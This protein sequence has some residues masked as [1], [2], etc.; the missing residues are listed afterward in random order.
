LGKFPRLVE[1]VDDIFSREDE[2]YQQLKQMYNDASVYA[3][4]PRLHESSLNEDV[5]SMVGWIMRSAPS[6]ASKGVSLLKSRMRILNAGIP[7]ERLMETAERIMEDD[8]YVGLQNDA[9]RVMEDIPDVRH[10]KTVGTRVN[11]FEMPVINRDTVVLATNG[12]T[13]DLFP[14][15]DSLDTAGGVAHHTG[16]TTSADYL[17]ATTLS[18]IATWDEATNESWWVKAGGGIR[19]AGAAFYHDGTNDFAVQPKFQVSIPDG[20]PSGILKISAHL[21]QIGSGR[22]V[23][24]TAGNTAFSNLFNTEDVTLTV[25]DGS[26]T[27]F[28]FEPGSGNEQMVTNR[29]VTKAVSSTKVINITMSYASTNAS[30]T[31]FLCMLEVEYKPSSVTLSSLNSMGVDLEHSDPVRRGVEMLI[32]YDDY[33]RTKQFPTVLSTLNARLGTNYGTEILYPSNWNT[34]SFTNFNTFL[35]EYIYVWSEFRDAI[36]TSPDFLAFFGDYY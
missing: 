26:S 22:T 28:T 18:V 21:R 14:V 4:L 3:K 1:K 2:A 31:G 16:G 7:G 12:G 24:P 17:I 6:I 23:N 20:V 25:S 35:D 10:L 9:K 30:V 19:Q 8:A 5:R 34:A 27:L 15:T 32:E 29:R 36:N 13:I 33:L 11:S